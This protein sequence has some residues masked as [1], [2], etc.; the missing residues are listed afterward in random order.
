MLPSRVRV[1]IWGR[2]QTEEVV[3]LLGGERERG[4]KR[5][6]KERMGSW[7]SETGKKGKRGRHFLTLWLWCVMMGMRSSVIKT[8]WTSVC[9]LF[10]I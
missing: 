9:E 2:S 5:R 10:F 8:M 1:P 7:E 3:V 6:G 4:V